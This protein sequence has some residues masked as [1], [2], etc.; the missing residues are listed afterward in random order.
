MATFIKGE[1]GVLSIWVAGAPGSYLPIGC[2]TSISMDSSLSVIESNTKCDP[3]VTI[4]SAGVFAYTLSI[5][6]NYIDTT[7]V[8]APD[9]DVLFSHDSFLALQRAGT[10][11]EFSLDTGLADTT[12][13]GEAII[14]DLS[15]S[16]GSGD[17]LAAF[18]VTLNGSGDVALVDPN[19]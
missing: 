1:T 11:I 17:E 5:D 14:S 9:L 15:A 6:G 13:Y 19:V 3:G 2:A 7:S 18:S 8:A 10:S 16:F 4:K 12:Y